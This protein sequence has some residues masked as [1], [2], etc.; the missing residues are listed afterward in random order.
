MLECYPVGTP[1]KVGDPLS[2]ISARISKIMLYGDDFDYEVVWFE[3]SERKSVWVKPFEIHESNPAQT[4][5]IGFR[6]PPIH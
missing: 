3:R 6:A 4:R 5:Q 2:P 1:V